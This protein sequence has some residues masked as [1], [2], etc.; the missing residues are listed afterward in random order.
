[1]RVIEAATALEPYQ[2]GFPGG[3]RVIY[4]DKAPRSRIPVTAT[5]RLLDI[6]SRHICLIVSQ[7]SSACDETRNHQW[8]REQ[9][10]E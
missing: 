4:T 3:Y 9:E 8:Q 10:H 6:C 5:L 2:S 1:M 7:M